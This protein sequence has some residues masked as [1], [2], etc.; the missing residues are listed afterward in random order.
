MS[1]K[2]YDAILRYKVLL[3]VV[4][5]CH[6]FFFSSRRRHTRFDCD[7]SSDVCSSDLA[8]GRMPRSPELP[9]EWYNTPNVHLF[10]IADFESFC[11]GH[12]IRILE[13]VALNRGRPVRDRKSVV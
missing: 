8:L 4:V 5:L 9:Y 10:T 12:G 2:R 13:R 7:W 3:G 11:S 1:C 6:S